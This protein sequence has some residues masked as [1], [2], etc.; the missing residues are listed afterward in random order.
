LLGLQVLASFFLKDDIDETGLAAKS[1]FLAN[2]TAGASWLTTAASALVVSLS[3]NNFNIFFTV[4][5][6]FYV[7][8]VQYYVLIFT[9]HRWF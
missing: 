9:N 5:M 3:A 8:H 6:Y 1:P 2:D 4:Y 7:L